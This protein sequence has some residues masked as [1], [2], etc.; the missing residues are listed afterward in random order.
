MQE[1]P[2]QQQSGYLQN[3]YY[4][5]QQRINSDWT[6]DPGTAVLLTIVTCGIYGFYVFY[7]LMLRRDE[8]LA[9]MA[10]VVGTSIALLSGKA[11]SEGK[12]DLIATELAELDMIQREMFNQSRERGAAL[13]LVLAILT[14]VAVWIG[15]YFLMDDMSK[16]D[17][18]EARYFTLMSGALEKMGL[19]SGGSQAAPSMPEREYVVF[20]LLS[21]VTCGIYYFYWL[22]VLVEDGNNHVEAQVQWED[23]IYSALSAA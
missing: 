5:V 22:Y 2:E 6:A 11:A 4:Y 14:G 8:H 9:R 17:Q 16:H 13:W 20:L 7:K 3:L 1:S 19:A 10:N 21:L 12:T 18:L 15:F 23:F